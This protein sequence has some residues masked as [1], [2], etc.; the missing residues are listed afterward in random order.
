MGASPNVSDHRYCQH[1][2]LTPALSL[3]GEG[4]L[5]GPVKELASVDTPTCRCYIRP[6][7]YMLSHKVVLTFAVPQ[8][9]LPAE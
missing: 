6:R 4:E 1:F 5:K 9:D 7:L 2:T 8:P 3:K